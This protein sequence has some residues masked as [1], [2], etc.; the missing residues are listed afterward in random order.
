MDMFVP[1]YVSDMP[2]LKFICPFPHL[3][4]QAKI[5]V[6]QKALQQQ[7]IVE[8]GPF[9]ISTILSNFPKP[10]LTYLSLSFKT[11]IELFYLLK[12]IIKRF[13]HE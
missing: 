7:K 13:C 9:A 4:R 5:V 12:N 1:G 11:V 8:K 3:N 2:S 6:I 10:N